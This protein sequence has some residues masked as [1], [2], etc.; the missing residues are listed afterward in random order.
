MPVAVLRHRSACLRWGPLALDKRASGR[1]MSVHSGW[2]EGVALRRH[3]L[4]LLVALAAAAFLI[5]PSPRAAEAANVIDIAAAARHSCALI[6]GGGVQCWGANDS[7][8][9][10][11]GTTE[12]RDA[13]VD[14]CAEYDTEGERCTRTLTGATTIAAGGLFSFGHTC[15]IIEDGRLQCWG[16]NIQGQLGTG[17]VGA[18]PSGEPVQFSPCSTV[19]ADVLEIGAVIAVAGGDS[20]TCAVTAA[21]GVK[22]WGWNYLGHL[23][24][25]TTD[26]ST[27]PVDVSG[28]DSGA[29]SVAAHYAHTCASLADG[30]VKCW[31]G[32]LYGSLGAETD[33]LCIDAFVGVELP[34]STTPVV[35]C[36]VEEPAED[37]CSE[38]LANA[39]AVDAGNNFSCAV[40]LAGDVKCWGINLSG[41]LGSEATG[42]CPSPWPTGD[43]APCSRVP[44]A[45]TG[46]SSTEDLA[47]GARHT[48]AVD[49][50]GGTKC[51]GGWNIPGLLGPGTTDSVTPLSVCERYDDV[52]GRCLRLL[53][54]V[55]GVAA[56]ALHTCVVTNVQGVKCWGWNISGQ[57]GSGV[58]SDEALNIPPRDVVGLGPKAASGDADCS[59]DVSSLDAAIVLQVAA[60]LVDGPALPAGR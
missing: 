60:A 55:S 47:I 44:V 10:G 6:D 51:W 16:T 13:P 43:P 56:G 50:H 8:Q 15:A 58:R 39:A 33:E 14:V 37:G 2:E 38:P 17:D 49:G 31:G 7:G 40:M 32:N 9:L 3:I 26:R 46:V 1:T 12:Y 34:C 5:W 29:V 48:C 54:G 57:L 30:G 53:S 52:A 42:E 22:C 18:C 23:G 41:R 36:T 28:L 45:V 24:D 19:P 59:G 21:G 20:H 27:I 11:D 4:A 35:V 25:G